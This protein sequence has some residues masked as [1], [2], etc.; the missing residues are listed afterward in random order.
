MSEKVV[1]GR[2][3]IIIISY[4]SM[5]DIDVCL[6]SVM[7][8]TYPDFEVIFV[9]NG[10]TDGSVEHARSQ[11]P[12]LKF[13]ENHENLG[14][15]RGINS[16]LPVATGEFIAPLNID[17]EVDPNWL[18][19]MVKALDSDTHIGAVTPKILLF[20]D[21]THINAMGHNVHVSGMGFCRRLNELDDGSIAP[22]KVSGLSGC[23]Y[24]IR[25]ETLDRMG[26]APPD[27]FMSNDDVIVSWLLHLMGFDIYCVPEAVVYHKYTLKMNPGKLFRLE[28]DR[29]QLVWST[30]K[31][32]TLVALSPVMLTVDVMTL[33]YGL[34]RGPAYV[35]ARL[36]ATRSLWRDRGQIAE[37]R[38]QYKSL[39]KVSDRRLL[40]SLRWGLEWRQLFG[41]VRP[42]G[43]GK[44]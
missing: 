33:A 9:D 40:R 21:R 18:E 10:S 12:G 8:Q 6:T 5:R 42:A 37:K 23:S 24:L 2:V 19:A 11:F 29:G 20:D 25:R 22:E 39:R 41:I 1:P 7:S 43:G 44:S 36:A 35:K 38:R 27:S 17:T 16:A 3:S 26:G 15:A 13:V 14:Y 34:V 4:N 30:L 28:R 32:L 31:P